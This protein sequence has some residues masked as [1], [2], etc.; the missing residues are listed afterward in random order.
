VLESSGLGQGRNGSGGLFKS[1]SRHETK[2]KTRL[3]TV[4]AGVGP[5]GRPKISK[6]KECPKKLMATRERISAGLGLLVRPEENQGPTGPG[7]SRVG[8]LRSAA[9][10][11]G[12]S[13]PWGNKRLS[14]EP[15]LMTETDDSTP[16]KSALEGTRGRFSQA[17]ICCK[18]T[19]VDGL[20]SRAGGGGRAR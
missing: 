4:D 5:G 14:C 15:I 12:S 10:G 9:S 13:S 6:P 17:S 19:L 7:L 20:M 8:H 16:A 1:L 18:L 3:K 11:S 2:Q